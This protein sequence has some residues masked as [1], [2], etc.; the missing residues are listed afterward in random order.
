MDLTLT[1][2]Q[3]GFRAL[4]R[5]FLDREVV[6]HRAE[7]DR[8]ESVDTAII[9]KLG[10]IGFMG[11]TIPE[12][13]G[14]IGGDY[15]TYV[16]AMEEL[17]R[18]DSAIRGIVSVSTGLFGKSVLQFGSEEQKQRWLPGIASGRLLGCFGLTEPDNGSD[19]GNLRTRAVRDGDEWVIDGSK[20]FITNGTWADVALV[21]ARTGGPG[22][23]G[24]SAFLVPTDT[25]GF[26]ATEVKGKLG[27]RGQATAALSFSGMR[28][29][30]DALL[31]E[32]GQGFRIAMTSLDKGR[33]GIAASCVGIIQGCLEA[34]IEY[35]TAR[36][37]FGRPIAS[38]QLVQD[39]IAEMSVD[40][41]A[42]RLLTW[43][44]ADLIDRGEKFSI[45]ASKAKL[46]ASEQAVKAA[47]LA[48]QV[49][50]GYGYV[51]E[52]PVQKYMRD[53]RVMTLYE[54][55]SQIQKLIIGRAETGISAFS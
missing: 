8:V 3:R 41:D 18:A 5:E 9:P 25:P 36:E 17:G 39:M 49:F 2:D 11:L 44:A 40:A 10:D 1:E 21:F 15:V 48:I 53:A 34:S 24:V 51:D 38:Y 27:L 14:G 33:V 52:Y 12:E 20:I 45:E 42:A 4:A 19:A 37:Q 16:L 13:Y 22:P 35:S 55:T 43:R 32:E 6:P 31:G 47:N 54:G 46:Y 7:W 28:V 50:G 23:K 30:S 29:P 26:E